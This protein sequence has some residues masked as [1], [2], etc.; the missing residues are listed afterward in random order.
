MKRKQIYIDAAQEREVKWLAAR[1]G[2]SEAFVIRE[3]VARYIA[4]EVE[5]DEGTSPDAGGPPSTAELDADPLLGIFGIADPGLP[6]DGSVT[7]DADLYRASRRT[8]R[9]RTSPRNR[10]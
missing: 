2:T 3:A 10:Q 7:H 9:R 6:P 8:A 5:R 1:R 4:D